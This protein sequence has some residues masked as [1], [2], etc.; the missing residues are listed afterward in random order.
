MLRVGILTSGGDCQGLNAAIRGVA[1]A[2][3]ESFD[4]IQ[5]YGILDG[6]RGLIEGKSRAM[7]PEDFSGILTLGGT[8]L[9]TSRQPFKRM[10]VVLNRMVG[11]KKLTREQADALAAEAVTLQFLPAS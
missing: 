7:K 10:Q 4:E 1:R 11:C 5:I 2:L 6:Y 3:Y 9:G 8:V